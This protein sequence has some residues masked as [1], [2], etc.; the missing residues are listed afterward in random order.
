MRILI[1][2]AFVLMSA[3]GT[4]KSPAET[5]GGAKCKADCAQRK[6]ACKDPADACDMRSSACMQTCT[7]LYPASK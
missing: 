5:V 1:V 4:T 6:A 7:D 3:C 2:L